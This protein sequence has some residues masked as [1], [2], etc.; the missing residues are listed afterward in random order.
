MPAK[1][2]KIPLQIAKNDRRIATSGKPSA[3]DKKAARGLLSAMKGAPI[4]IEL[5]DGERI[6]TCKDPPEVVLKVR[7]RKALS[8]CPA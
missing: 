6:Q 2:K 8:G 1:S 7:N 4:V 5:W 3:V